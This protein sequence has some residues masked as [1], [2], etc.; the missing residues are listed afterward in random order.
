MTGFKPA[1][2]AM[3]TDGR[4]TPLYQIG[5]FLADPP[6][7]GRIGRWFVRRIYRVDDTLPGVYPDAKEVADGALAAALRVT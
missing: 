6:R 1:D 4:G 3:R 5:I 7:K 2:V